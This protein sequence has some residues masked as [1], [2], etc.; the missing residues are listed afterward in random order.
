[1]KNCFIYK[2]PIGKLLVCTDDIFLTDLCFT[3]Q[4]KAKSSSV[5]PAPC[6]QCYRISVAGGKTGIQKE[7]R[8]DPRVSRTH[9]RM[10]IIKQ[11]DSYFT[12]K[13]K[14]FDLP[15]KLTGT[16]FQKSVWKALGRIPYGQVR[17]YSDI[18]K[19]IKKPKAVR[20]VGT[21][22]GNNPIGIV[23]P[24]HRVIRSDGKI[25]EFA[26]GVKIK[27]QLLKLESAI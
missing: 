20:A 6:P 19:M 11:L 23:L 12:G 9:P 3:T 18:A 13:L 5:I 14:K 22:I 15:I 4:G 26:W 21:A 27:K 16:T 8:M 10:T 24:C 7:N 1:M 17:S 25:G 2:S